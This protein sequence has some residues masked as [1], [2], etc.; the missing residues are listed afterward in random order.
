MAPD[1]GPASVYAAGSMSHDLARPGALRCL[2]SHGLT[3]P[4]SWALLNGS[5]RKSEIFLECVEASGSFDVPP[6]PGC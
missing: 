5:G 1:G 6:R 3:P 4:P 2:G